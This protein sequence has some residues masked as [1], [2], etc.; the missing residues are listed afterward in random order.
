M[1]SPDRQAVAKM[2]VAIAKFSC[3]SQYQRAP[4]PE[5]KALLKDALV[6]ICGTSGEPKLLS[7]S[8]N[9]ESDSDDEFKDPNE[10]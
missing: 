8:I 4:Y 2:L 6:M 1:V 7:D 9:I 5:V 10:S 3:S